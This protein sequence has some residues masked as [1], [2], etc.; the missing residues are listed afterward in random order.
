MTPNNGAPDPAAT[1]A[2]LI[3]HVAEGEVIREPLG[4]GALWRIGPYAPSRRSDQDR[5]AQ[6]PAPAAPR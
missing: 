2:A 1:E 4:D 6:G 5:T 3:D